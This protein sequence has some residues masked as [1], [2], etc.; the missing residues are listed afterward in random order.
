MVV[1]FVACLRVKR[2]RKSDTKVVRRIG[3]EHKRHRR[4]AAG[5]DLKTELLYAR[6]SLSVMRACWPHGF[7]AT[8]RVKHFDESLIRLR[9]PT[10]RG[11]R[12]KADH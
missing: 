2:V 8:P 12:L 3:R 5:F 10:R 4:A 11:N 7:H 1:H 6:C 9:W